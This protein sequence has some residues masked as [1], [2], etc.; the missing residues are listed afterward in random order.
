M[1]IRCHPARNPHG[2]NRLL[3][4]ADGDSSGA[5]RN[6]GPGATYHVLGRPFPVRRGALPMRS[7]RCAV[8]YGWMALAAWAGAR[9][10]EA[11]TFRVGVGNGCTHATA[12]AALDAAAAS[13]GGDLVL[14]SRSVAY[15]QQQLTID[16]G[17]AVDL[18]ILGGY[19]TCDQA[20]QDG[21]RT[22]LS[23]AGGAA[24]PVL[25]V[26]SGSQLFLSQ[27]EL[28]GGESGGLRAE[29][30]NVTLRDVLIRN[31]SA[32]CGGGVYI[33]GIAG[34]AVTI[35]LTLQE[36]VSILGNTASFGGGGICA[37]GASVTM[38]A[39]NSIIANNEATGRVDAG[40]GQLVEGYGGGVY[41]SGRGIGVFL[42]PAVMLV[43]STGQGN[44]GAIWNNT[45]R[46]GGGVALQAAANGAARLSLVTDDGAVPAAIRSNFASVYGGAVYAE[47]YWDA[48]PDRSAR[49][50]LRIR[51]G[52]LEDNASPVGAA[53]YLANAGGLNGLGGELDMDTLT[54]S[55][56]PLATR[57]NR[58]SNNDAVDAGGV[59][60]AISVIQANPRARVRIGKAWLTGNRYGSLLQVTGVQYQGGS[61][62]VSD[63]L[64]AGNQTPGVLFRTELADARLTL[65][66]LTVAGNAIGFGT[67]I[68]NDGPASLYNSI[69]YQPGISVFGGSGARTV[70]YVLAHETASLAGSATVLAGDPRFIDAAAGDYR[71]GASSPAVD[72]APATSS[73]DLVGTPRAIDLGFVSNRFG[74]GDVGAFERPSLVPIAFNA[75]FDNS[76]AGWTELVPG[77]SSWNAANAGGGTGSGSMFV[78]GPVT[79]GATLVPRSQCMY[80]PGPGR[81]R[82]TGFGRSVGGSITTRDQL[83]LQWQLRHDGGAG[84]NGGAANGQGS[85][86]LSANSGFVSPATPA[87]IEITP[88]QWTRNTSLVVALAVTDVGVVAP[89]NAVGYFDAISITPLEPDPVFVD[90]FE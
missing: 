81:Y 7:W 23:G 67:A 4:Q 56:C 30:I 16:T 31:N 24:A 70:G 58:I 82:L 80:L 59:P 89:S 29:R 5:R 54:G 26:V 51:D 22:V 27:V 38:T 86:F 2:A 72:F 39:P 40:S 76:V 53:V 42:N 36:N 49:A 8:R 65:S 28:S 84:C 41:L 66:G 21:I 85:L 14:L 73:G 19:A 62:A 63:S 52:V 17:N 25:R 45:A 9:G 88:A 61:A 1:P 55:P 15:T 75:D 13:S 35:S 18:S 64:V 11:A 78:S 43:G 50:E 10:V 44:L 77:V 47:P 48:D 71:P 33:A 87:E 83:Y 32:S 79:P 12:Q 74:A 20:A 69:V 3:P 6:I 60:S 34:S 46:Y 57:C 90:S 37:I 68:L